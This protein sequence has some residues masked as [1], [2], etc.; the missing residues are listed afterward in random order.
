MPRLRT[1]ATDQILRSCHLCRRLE[2]AL[3]SEGL[4]HGWIRSGRPCPLAIR[5]HRQFSEAFPR[6]H[7]RARELYRSA[8]GP[9]VRN[10]AADLSGALSLLE[11]DFRRHFRHGRRFWSRDELPV[12]HELERFRR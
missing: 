7:D 10:P 11:E 3:T 1:A 4:A 12:W 8:R 6:I 9:V 5:L 2:A